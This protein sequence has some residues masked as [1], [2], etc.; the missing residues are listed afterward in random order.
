FSRMKLAEGGSLTK[1]Y[2]L[3][4]EGWAEYEAWRASATH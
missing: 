3:S 4:D 1:Y 2:P